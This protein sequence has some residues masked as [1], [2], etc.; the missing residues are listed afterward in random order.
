MGTGAVA[1]AAMFSVEGDEDACRDS[2]HSLTLVLR[3]THSWQLSVGL[4]R[5]CFFLG[6]RPGVWG[7]LVALRGAWGLGEGGGGVKTPAMVGADARRPCQVLFPVE[8]TAYEQ[9]GNN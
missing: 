6:G 8:A 3:S 2:T 1:L 7:A 4:F 9:D 5:F